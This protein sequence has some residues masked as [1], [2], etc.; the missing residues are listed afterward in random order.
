MFMITR[1]V[2]KVP[3]LDVRENRANVWYFRV[4]CLMRCEITI[5]GNAD[6]T[7]FKDITPCSVVNGHQCLGNMYFLYHSGNLQWKQ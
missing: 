6:I 5:A 7:L 1:H 4:H 3:P 2:E